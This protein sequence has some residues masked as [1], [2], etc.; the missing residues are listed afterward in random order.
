MTTTIGSEGGGG[1]ISFGE[2]LGDLDGHATTM[3]CSY[4]TVLRTAPATTWWATQ[5]P[6]A[7]TLGLF[8]AQAAASAR[9]PG[10]GQ[11]MSQPE[12]TN[13]SPNEPVT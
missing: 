12:P 7:A 3:I 2:A 8:L 11:Q 5:T 9:Q 6:E 10:Q 13:L 4:T 1:A